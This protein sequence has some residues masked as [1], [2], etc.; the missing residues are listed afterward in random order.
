[1]GLMNLGSKL[2]NSALNALVNLGLA[3]SAFFSFLYP[4]FSNWG[5]DVVRVIA[6]LLIATVCLCVR[7]LWRSGT[8]GRAVVALL[9][10]LPVLFL[11]GELTV[12]EG[13][14]Y[15][16]AK[17]TTPLRFQ[18]RG[19]SGFWGLIIYRSE[20]QASERTRDNSEVMWEIEWINVRRFPSMHLEFPYGTPPA[21]YQSTK[22]PL[23]LDPKV[24]YTLIIRPAMGPWRCYS[25]QGGDITEYSQYPDICHDPR[26]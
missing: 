22:S 19:P 10:C 8:R 5:F 20:R 16:S 7:D 1:M 18:V 9:L 25:L 2:Q 24:A 4:R 14:L 15:I 6:L 12:W 13:P 26:L 17:P 11:F 21:G 23:P 3:T